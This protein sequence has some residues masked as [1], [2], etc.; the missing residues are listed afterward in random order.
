MPFLDRAL[1]PAA[2]SALFSSATRSAINCSLSCATW[3]PTSTS[4]T[5]KPVTRWF[6]RTCSRA[7]RSK[8][9]HLT[10]SPSSPSS[11]QSVA[12]AYSKFRSAIRAAPIA[13]ERKLAGGTAP[14]PYGRSCI[15]ALRAA[16]TPT[17]PRAEKSLKGSIALRASTNGWRTSLG[18]TWEIESSK[19]AR[20]SAT[21]P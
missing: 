21:C 5:W 3:F 18:L 4:P 14:A 17:T 20:V 12:R 7:F 15:T 1:C 6:A 9:P 10:W 13:K 11:W 16:F 2:T 19:S 8:A